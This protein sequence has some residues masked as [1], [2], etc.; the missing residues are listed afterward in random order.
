M[1]TTVMP[2]RFVAPS[3]SNSPSSKPPIRPAF[4][5]LTSAPLSRNKR[6]LENLRRRRRPLRGTDGSNP[7]LS[8]GESTN[9]RF[10]GGEAASAVCHEPA[11][12]YARAAVDDATLRREDKAPD[13][14]GRPALRCTD[15]GRARYPGWSARRPGS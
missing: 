13:P 4:L 3:A 6:H 1:G 11:L 9:H 12:L 7:A 14:S 10:L 2:E 15:R 5:M 8:S